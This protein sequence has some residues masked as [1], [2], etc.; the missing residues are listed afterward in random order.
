MLT[1]TILVALVSAFFVI[2]THKTGIRNYVIENCK[3]ELLSKL[4]ACDFCYCFWLNAIICVGLAFAYSDYTMLA[5]P[6]L[7]TPITRYLV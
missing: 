5:I 7:S 1:D 3:I 2:F 4:F 6:Y